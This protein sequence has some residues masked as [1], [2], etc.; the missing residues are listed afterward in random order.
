MRLLQIK[1]ASNLNDL[2]VSQD[3][4]GN[5]H[6]VLGMEHTTT[7]EPANKREAQLA[8][9]NGGMA[10][11]VNQD[12]VAYGI[13]YGKHPMSGGTSVYVAVPKG[14]PGRDES[15]RGLRFLNITKAFSSIKGRSFK[16]FIG[17]GKHK[18]SFERD[19]KV[20]PYKKNFESEA[21]KFDKVIKQDA[22]RAYK[23]IRTYLVDLIDSVP[24]SS[25]P[26]GYKRSNEDMNNVKKVM[27]SM[28]RLADNGLRS[29][30][31]GVEHYSNTGLKAAMSKFFGGA[32]GP[33]VRSRADDFMQNEK[34]SVH[35]FIKF[36]RKEIR[37]H[38]E[39]A[40]TGSVKAHNKSASEYEKE[41]NV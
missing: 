6:R 39:R 1:E 38:V 34:L 29:W 4:V 5:I 2:G 17:K 23:E 20:D 26:S 24:D 3:D 32:Y 25:S 10:I 36:M 12:G 37:N 40:I 8:V 41:R 35:K 9:K 15:W 14:E 31:D 18:S 11:A 19:G 16:Y 27:Q 22:A 28:K 13:G 21:L 30:F 7:F 33:E